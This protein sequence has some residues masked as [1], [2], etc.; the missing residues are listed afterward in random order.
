VQVEL[1]DLRRRDVDVVGASPV[2]VVGGAAYAFYDT[3][4]VADTALELFASDIQLEPEPE[5]PDVV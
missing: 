4:E 3:G 5:P 1:A 2:V